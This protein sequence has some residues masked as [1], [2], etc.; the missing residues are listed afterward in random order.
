MIK[1]HK[2]VKYTLYCLLIICLDLLQNVQ[3]L[4]VEI[5][6]A[7]CFLLLPA[8]IIMSMGEDE[9]T[10]AFIGLFA[11]LL[12]DLT[13][14]AH[15]GFNCIFI[16]IMCFFSAAFVTYIARDTFITNMLATIITVFMYCLLYWLFFIIIK[17][18][19]GAQMTIVTFY[20]PCMIYT[21][22]LSPVLWLIINPLKRKYKEAQRNNQSLL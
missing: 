6:G 15:M 7:R 4:F 20:L 8:V 1:R 11:G 2:A 19:D 12:W 3:G 21:L 17:G 13:S 5:A 10:A 18:I 14:G 9:K 16:M 22:A